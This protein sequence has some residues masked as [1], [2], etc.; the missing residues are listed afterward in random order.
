MARKRDSVVPRRISLD[1]H[2]PVV[3]KEDTA[4]KSGDEDEEA[5][6][7]KSLSDRDTV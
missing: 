4:E 2:E 3:K 5:D 7:V 1:S 6:V